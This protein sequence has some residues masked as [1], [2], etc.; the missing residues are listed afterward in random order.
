MT[1]GQIEESNA[2]TV[3]AYLSSIIKYMHKNGI[4]LRNFRSETLVFEGLESWDIKLMDL[5][6]AIE[7]WQYRENSMDGL[8]DN[9]A[10]LQPLY[11]APELFAAKKKYDE[12]VDM[13][14]MGCLIFNMVT[15]VPPFYESDEAALRS[16]I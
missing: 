14:S 11:R 3:A 5:S 9:Y 6:L 8:F 12:A 4:I 10:K 1:Q 16:S 2:A 13:W 7:K 15:G